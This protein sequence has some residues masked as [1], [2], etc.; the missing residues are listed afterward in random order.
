MR[1]WFFSIQL[2]VANAGTNI[3]WNNLRRLTQ[4]LYPP[5]TKVMSDLMLAGFMDCSRFLSYYGVTDKALSCLTVE[6]HLH[7]SQRQV[8]EVSISKSSFVSER[9]EIKYLIWI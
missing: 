1:K 2:Y 7:K 5:R 4:V 8:K 9:M 3:T 6:S